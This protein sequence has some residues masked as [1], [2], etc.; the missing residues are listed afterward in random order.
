MKTDKVNKTLTVS[1]LVKNQG[2]TC[3]LAIDLCEYF[4]THER[5]ITCE[6]EKRLKEVVGDS[7]VESSEVEDEERILEDLAE[8]SYEK[9][10]IDEVK[11]KSYF[12]KIEPAK[13][14][15]STINRLINEGN[16]HLVIELKFKLRKEKEITNDKD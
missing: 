8:D 12:D 7:I 15:Q 10:I 1:E 11:R 16:N 9:A 4:H 2:V 14:T 13:K 6:E 5:L 3:G